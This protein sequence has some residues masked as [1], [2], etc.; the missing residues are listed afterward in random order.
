[1]NLDRD[2]SEWQKST[3]NRVF[4]FV[5]HMWVGIQPTTVRG[6]LSNFSDDDKWIG[7]TLLDMLVFYNEEQE[8][9]LLRALMN[10]LKHD[11]WIKGYLG[12]QN[13]SSQVLNNSFNLILQKTVFVPVVIDGPADSGASIMSVFKK[14]G[15]PIPEAN[16]CFQQ[17]TEQKIQEG[18]EYVVFFDIIIGTGS[19]FRTFWNKPL[20]PDNPDSAVGNIAKNH[21]HIKLYYITLNA[22][23]TELIELKEEFKDITIISA[24]Q[25]DEKHKCISEENEYWSWNKYLDMKSFISFLNAK[26]KSFNYQFKYDLQLPFLYQHSRPINN[27][28]PLYWYES[29]DW[30]PIT[31]RRER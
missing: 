14:N 24:E 3:K 21:S 17:Y 19:Q 22:Y 26:I 2:I 10:K 7:Y 16:F 31:P 4:E 13:A 6:F 27:A 25:C 20:T 8:A 9:A 15:I 18:F 12:S 23:E 29:E 5:N 11:M 30:K 28:C 1:M